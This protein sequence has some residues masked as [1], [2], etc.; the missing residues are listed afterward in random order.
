MSLLLVP[1][2]VQLFPETGYTGYPLVF[3]INLNADAANRRLQY[4]IDGSY[5]DNSTRSIT[6]SLVTYNGMPRTSRHHT[7]RVSA[8]PG[9]CSSYQLSNRV[10]R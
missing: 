8:S 4:L 2:A 9:V 6:V 5:I 1:G 10:S 3:D 7:L